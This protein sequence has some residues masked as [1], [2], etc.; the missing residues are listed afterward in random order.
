MSLLAELK[1]R[2]VFRVGIAYVAVGWLVVEVTDTVAPALNMPDW[3]LTVVIWF[4]IVGFPFALLFAWAFEL[5]S[6]GIKKTREVEP[7]APLNHSTARKLE[8]GIIAVLMVA[9]GIL[10][11]E[12]YVWNEQSPKTL[13]QVEADAATD[14]QDQ[15]NGIYFSG[16]RSPSLGCCPSIRQHEWG[17]RAGVLRQWHY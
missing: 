9:L 14:W 4:G 5:T 1:R 15:D 17:P 7:G 16:A 3:T 13:G 2:N 12:A 11:L 6:A 8:I 10:V